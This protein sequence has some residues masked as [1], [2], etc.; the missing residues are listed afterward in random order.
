MKKIEEVLLNFSH[1]KYLFI[2]CLL[3]SIKVF[4]VLNNSLSSC[5][6]VSLCAKQWINAENYTELF[7]NDVQQYN[8]LY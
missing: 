3:L 8:I 7:S 4:V 1:T 2:S 6:E 5:K